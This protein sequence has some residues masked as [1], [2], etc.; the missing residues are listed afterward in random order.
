MSDPHDEF[1]GKNVLIERK[2]SKDPSEIT[3]K[4]SMSIETYKDILGECRRKLFEVRSRRARP[5]LDDKVIVSWNGLAISSFSRASKILLGEVEGTKFYFPVVGTEPKEYMQIAEKA[6]LFIKK[7]L[8]NAETQ[9]LNHSFR[10]S[11]SKAP[12]FLDDY[13]FLIS[14]LLDLY[15]FGG[16]INWLQWAIELQGTQDALFLDGDGGG[17]FNNTCRW[18]FQF[19]SV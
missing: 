19:F 12:G 3:S 5:H 17:Y 18:I 16:G 2:K 7:E 10:N 8:H 11:P 9:R 15:E 14:G 1:K 4:Y 13:A 6:A